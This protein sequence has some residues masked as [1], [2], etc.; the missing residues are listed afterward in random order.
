MKFFYLCKLVDG[1][2][3]LGF[4]DNYDAIEVAKDIHLKHIRQGIEEIGGLY[5]VTVL[6]FNY[7]PLCV[8]Y[9]NSVEYFKGVA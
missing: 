1:G 6:D 2:H 9:R 7:K 8:L 4:T 3:I 5:P